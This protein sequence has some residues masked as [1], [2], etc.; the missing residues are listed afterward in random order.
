MF[1]IA[2]A[3]SP[4]VRGGTRR[5][6]AWSTALLVAGTLLLDLHTP[7][8]IAAW[9]LYLPAI[10]TSV[11]WGGR[12]AMLAVTG[13]VIAL[14]FL[15]LRLSP[16]GDLAA[17]AV[18]RGIFAATCLLL[19]GLCWWIDHYRAVLHRNEERFRRLFNN[20]AVGIAVADLD[21]NLTQ[22]NRTYCLL[23]GYRESEL[24]GRS[25]LSFTHPDDVAENLALWDRLLHDQRF[26]STQEKRYVRKDGSVIWVKVTANL[27]RPSDGA[28]PLA[29]AIIE[30]ISERRRTEEALQE[31]HTAV[32]LAVE[33]ISRLDD[34]GRYVSVN[35]QYASA[36]GYRP[37]ELIGQSWEVTVHPGDREAVQTAFDRMLATGRG[38]TELRGLR[39][40][41]TV[42]R[43]Q[44]VIVK[45]GKGVPGHY[46]LMW[47]IT[48]RKRM[49]EALRQSYAELE[50]R[51]QERTAD[52]GAANARLRAEVEERQRADKAMRESTQL[53]HTIM[54]GIP[55]A[56]FVK[57]THGR[58]LLCNAAT[59]RFVGKQPEEILGQD[60]SMLFPARDADALMRQDRDVMAGG[61]AVSTEET[62]TMADGEPRTFLSTRG[63]LFDAEGRVSGIFGIARDI[64]ERKRMELNLRTS[65]ARLRSLCEAMPHMVWTAE[66]DGSID[67]V[68]DCALTYFGVSLDA[69]TGW[70]WEQVVH[71]ED[72]P[73]CR[74]RWIK[75]LESGDPYEVE[76]RLRRA[77]DRSYRWHLARALA[78]RGQDGRILK[79]HGACADV[80]D[81]KRA[82]EALKHNERHLNQA[83]EI[84]HLGSWSWDVGTNVNTWSDENYRIFGYAPKSI[85]PNYDVF[86]GSL[87]PDDRERVL[88][89]ASA[90]LES[91]APYDLE[92]RI[93][94]PD[95]TVRHVHCRGTVVRDDVGRPLT[96]AGTVLDIT[97]RKHL[98]AELIRYNE[99]LEQRVNER[100]ERIRE[101]ESQRAQ[102]EK[103]AALGQLAAGVAHEINNPIAGIK[104]AFLLVKQAVPDAHP[105]ASFVP[106]IDRE[107]ERVTSIVR[108]MYQL[109]R[110][111]PSPLAPV[112]C[113]AVVRDVI[114]LFAKRSKSRGIALVSSVDHGL[115]RVSIPRG[116]LFQVLVNLV[117]NAIECSPAGAAIEI[118][119][120]S[121]PQDVRIAVADQGTGIAPDV[122]PHLF[123]PFF[124]TKTAGDQKNMGLGLSVSHNLVRAM[125]GIIEVE[126]EETRGSTFTVVLPLSQS[127]AVSNTYPHQQEEEL[128]HDH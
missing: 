59:S 62:I 101:L 74:N 5:I 26:S 19:A 30:D 106:M 98:E 120:W 25:F 116:D 32:E 70:R 10:V 64:T 18:N 123:E 105:H 115:P 37:D 57:D 128:T 15:G 21:T 33:G 104:N 127:H 4:I 36:I 95:G 6:L 40:D 65:E 72:L 102:A 9:A 24:I 12:R 8:G 92:C 99:D 87:H 100:A 42:F 108:H 51:V 124:T 93:V 34:Q 66:P 7:L 79:W 83:Q 58:Y 28:R 84:A 90:A 103:L 16:P 75:A 73:I 68:N 91:D 11:F 46:C 78:L 112:D 94:R 111:A 107:I 88:L 27:F 49:E 86:A 67:Y 76:F 17:A 82:E 47:D 2:T 54:E 117:Q 53:M 38:E 85:Q 126:S 113:L 110:R 3:D 109:Y 89:A 39:K 29:I 50:Q 44:V 43:K 56:V 1:D 52:L 69:M 96:M 114:D 13:C 23:L 97:A 125:G 55:D 35:A 41:G 80:E 71:P 63:P 60:D 81:V 22:V 77:S 45:P 119:A 31:A 61:Q 118:A 20:A 121:T 48:D 122:R 14:G